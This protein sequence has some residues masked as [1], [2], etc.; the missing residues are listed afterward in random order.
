MHI[1]EY[2]SVVDLHSDIQERIREHKRSEPMAPVVL[3]TDSPLQGLLLRRQLV[4]SSEA[5]A[6]GNIQVKMIDE[7]ISDIFKHTG[8][9]VSSSPSAAALDAACYSAMLTNATFASAG[10]DALTTASGISSVYSKLRFNTDIELQTLLSENLSD[11]QKAVIETVIAARDILHSKLGVDRLPEKIEG[12]IDA[13]KSGATPKL[14]SVLY[15]VLTENLPR[16]VGGLFDCLE[17][18]VRYEV[19]AFEPKIKTA[20]K[21]FSAPDPQTEAALAVSQLVELVDSETEPSEVAMVY[22]NESQYVRLLGT[23]LD[24]AGISWHGAMDKISQSSNLYRGFNLILQMLE[25]RTTAKSGADR[26]LVM[27]LL[28][29]G[30]FYVD[31]MLLDSNLCRQF[32]RDKEIYGDAISWLKVIGKLPN[33]TKPREVKAAGELKALLKALQRGLQN[34]AEAT[35]WT[36]F[37]SE[38][39][40]IVRSFY[41]GANEDNLSDDEK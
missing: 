4:D 37:G 9:K 36:E 23:A 29:S 12:A 18:C 34:I 16:L 19:S 35:N 6:V 25:K 8:S 26:P 33:A 3:V 17:T 22:S 13:I 40:E 2:A 28:E 31:D 41:L 32:V 27:R 15:L 30:D 10:S 20:Q 5:G 21:Y 38:L 24:D 14:P 1:I 39:F 11:T 7:V